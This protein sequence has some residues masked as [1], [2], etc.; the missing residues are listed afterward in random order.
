MEL[1]FIISVLGLA[2]AVLLLT[3]RRASAHCDT[4]D[5][6]TAKDGIKALETGNVNYAIKWVF[7]EGEQEVREAFGLS[8]KV[9][10]L[11]AEAKELADRYFI[12]TLIRVH[13]A[14][15]GAPFT[16]VKPRGTPVDKKVAAAD[17][18]LEIGN[19]TPLKG[20]VTHE[21]MHDLEKKFKRAM[22]LKDFDVN[23]VDAAREYIEAY[24]I[25]FKTA[26]G[27]GDVHSHG[28]GH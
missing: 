3:P 20:L 9:R 7:P 26:E 25:F 10:K 28:H 17:K 27:H 16:G 14:G 22:A 13:R 18:S 11:G 15:E 4:M 1:L 6:P 2:A 12:D 21:E 8:L 23:D 5:G 24:V 19:L